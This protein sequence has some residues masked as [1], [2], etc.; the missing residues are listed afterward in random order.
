[1]LIREL[2]SAFGSL[3]EDLSVLPASREPGKTLL[4]ETLV[5]CMSEFGRTPGPISETRKGREH[6]I[7]IHS[8]M[9]AGGGVARGGVIGKSD[10]IG[11]QVD[12]PGW[13]GGRAI[14]MEDVACTIYS[15]LG[16]DWTKRIADTPSGR[17]YHYVEPASGTSY[18]DFQPISELF[19]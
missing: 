1:M 16:I 19:G 18:M 2:D 5:V 15:A 14:Y 4:D 9:F 17:P 12:E 8:G 7:H 13:S 6:H 3:I 11:G 10:E